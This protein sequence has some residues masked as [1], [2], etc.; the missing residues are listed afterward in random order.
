MQDARRAIFDRHATHTFRRSVVSDFALSVLKLRQRR[1]LE[2][3][4]IPHPRPVSHAMTVA[5]PSPYGLRFAQSPRVAISHLEPPS[6]AQSPRH[7]RAVVALVWP[8][9]S[10]TR[11]LSLLLAEPDIRLR[12]RKGQVK[13]TFHGPSAEA[14][15]KGQVGIGDTVQLG[16]EG[17]QWVQTNENVST[18]GKKIEWDLVFDGR[19][20]LDVWGCVKIIQR[21]LS[22]ACIGQA[23]LSSSSYYQRRLSYSSLGYRRS[24]MDTTAGKLSERKWPYS[25]P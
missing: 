24:V 12:K 10:S 5:P 1:L 4:G 9:S 7:I 11:A 14:V 22:D 17:A 6:D 20:D 3:A 18:P 21:K 25:V 13:V 8:Y 16:L 23:R 19:A 15:A 2:D